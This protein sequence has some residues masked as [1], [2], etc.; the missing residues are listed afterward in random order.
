MFF[1]LRMVR[2]A[3]PHPVRYFVVLGCALDFHWYWLHPHT[4]PV[5]QGLCKNL[6]GTTKWS[7]HIIDFSNHYFQSAIIWFWIFFIPTALITC[8]NWVV[9]FLAWKEDNLDH[10]II[11]SFNF[12]Y[13]LRMAALFSTGLFMANMLIEIAYMVLTVNFPN[14]NGVTQWVSRVCMY[15]D[16]IWHAQG[17]VPR[18]CCYLKLAIEVLIWHEQGKVRRTCYICMKHYS[19]IFSPSYLSHPSSPHLTSQRTVPGLLSNC[20]VE[21]KC[22][23]AFSVIGSCATLRDGTPHWRLCWHPLDFDG[24]VA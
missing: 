10:M 24:F 11:F 8:I 13:K 16:E 17:Y 5:I 20:I 9:L 19:S 1:S 23:T 15:R 6:E 18:T 12:N 14:T 3:L 7:L 22:Y 21:V 2:S 4:R